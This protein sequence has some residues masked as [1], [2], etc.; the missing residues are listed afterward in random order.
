[1]KKSRRDFLDTYRQV[2]KPMIPS[3]KVIPN[4]KDIRKSERFDWRQELEEQEQEDR[5]DNYKGVLDD[6]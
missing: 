2:R 5:Y 1:M 3:E 6:Q 4:E